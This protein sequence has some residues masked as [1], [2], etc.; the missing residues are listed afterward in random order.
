MKTKKKQPRPDVVVE[1]FGGV[2]SVTSIKS[3]LLCR[4]IDHDNDTIIDNEEGYNK[5][6]G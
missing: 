2:A 1:V 5:T 3:G 6:K 4:I